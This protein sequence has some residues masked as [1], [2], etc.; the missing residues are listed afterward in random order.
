MTMEH[1]A[2]VERA[3]R[4]IAVCE[5]K[6]PDKLS[7]NSFA[8][9]RHYVPHAHAVNASSQAEIERLR[10]A[11]E[12]YRD[13]FQFHTDPRRAGLEWKPTETLLD[14]CGNVARAALS[15]AQP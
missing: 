4:L 11:L 10:T 1:T 8:W 3:A 5:G 2:D 14:D 9:W 13:G 7:H 15:E 6:D 12:F